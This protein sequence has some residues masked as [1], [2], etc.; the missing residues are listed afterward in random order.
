MVFERKGFA[1]EM[2]SNCNVGATTYTVCKRAREEF[3][4]MIVGNHK[5]HYLHQT[6]TTSSNLIFCLLR[7]IFLDIPLYQIPFDDGVK[8]VLYL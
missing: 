6:T 4:D 8:A 7:D 5:I 2:V 3:K 1:R